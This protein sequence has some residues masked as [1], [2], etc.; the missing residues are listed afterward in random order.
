MEVQTK[1]PKDLKVIDVIQMPAFE[2]HIKRLMGD[3]REERIGLTIHGTELKRD[4]IKRL[5]EK[6]VYN[7]K[8]FASLYVK[9]LDKELDTSEYPSTL[10]IFIKR[11]CDEALYRTATQIKDS[12]DKKD[13]YGNK[14]II[15]A[16]YFNSIT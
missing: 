7:P 6:G 4:P 5:V 1:K 8:A 15:R 9:I 10:R 3:L 12:E 13:Y 2:D 14:R 11:L 16:K